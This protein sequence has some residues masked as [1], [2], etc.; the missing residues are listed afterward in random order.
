MFMKEQNNAFNKIEYMKSKRNGL[1]IAHAHQVSHDKH[2]Y[3]T[4]RTMDL[5][6]HNIRQNLT[7]AK[8]KYQTFIWDEHASDMI[9]LGGASQAFLNRYVLVDK[10]DLPKGRSKTKTPRLDALEPKVK[11]VITKEVDGVIIVYEIKEIARYNKIDV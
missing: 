6:A 1:W 10:D 4:G 5:L 9:Y 8:L 11:D 2:I 7:N 3:A